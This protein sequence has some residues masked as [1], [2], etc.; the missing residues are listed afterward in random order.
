MG[1]SLVGFL[2]PLLLLA[3]GLVNWSLIGLI[4][5][6]AF[7]VFQF[8]ASN[9]G[10]HYRRRSL[11]LWST[12]IFSLL[13]ILCQSTFLVLWATHGDNWSAAETWWAKLFGFM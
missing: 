13:V 8:S 7:L 1:S 11:L 5:L 3:A 4:D 12:I 6:I 9:L 2:L 10:F